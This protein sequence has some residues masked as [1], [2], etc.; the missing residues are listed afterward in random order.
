[1]DQ[2]DPEFAKAAMHL[3]V[4]EYSEPVQTPYG[5]HLIK[6]TDRQALDAGVNDAEVRSKISDRVKSQKQAVM[7][8]AL[9]DSLKAGAQIEKLTPPGLDLPG[10]MGQE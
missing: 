4:G 1:M 2:I 9:M 3:N 7:F 6:L 10:G 5:F 8:K